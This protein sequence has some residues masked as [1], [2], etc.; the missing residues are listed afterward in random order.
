M[1]KP[2]PAMI[3]ALF[4]LFVGL[5]GVGIAANGQS[6]IL[7]STTNSATSKT[8]LTAP[9]DDHV[10]QLTNTN[11]GKNATAL[12]L[13]VASGHTP[14]TV[15]TQRKVANLNAD[16]LDGKD[17]SAFL[18]SSGTVEQW[19]SPFEYRSPQFVVRVDPSAGPAVNVTSSTAGEREVYLSLNK[20]SILGA[21]LKLKSV[22][23]CFLAIGAPITGTAVYD[24]DGSQLAALSSD[25][26]THSSP[27]YTCYDVGPTTPTVV[28]RSLYLHLYLEYGSSS[29]RILLFPV[30]ATFVT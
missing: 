8:V 24:G 13:S 19:Y 25:S 12:G 5:G 23:I 11:T 16:Q 1:R 21:T 18:P 4:G 9:I 26:Y 14:F 28:T 27:E 6:L 22:T 20:P 7:G 10:L 29:D 3:V 15:N 2:S 30:K 17:A